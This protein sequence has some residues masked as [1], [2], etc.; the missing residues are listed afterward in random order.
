ME[1]LGAGVGLVLGVVRGP[2][3]SGVPPLW[4][5]RRRGLGWGGAWV[6]RAWCR[7]GGT[8]GGGGVCPAG[9]AWMNREDEHKE[10]RDM[11]LITDRDL[12]LMEPTLC[13]DAAGAA[14]VLASG[15]GTL[16]SGVLSIAGVN[17]A[18][19]GVLP[20]QLAVVGEQVVEIVSVS[21]AEMTV[22][23]MRSD[24]AGPLLTPPDAAAVPSR[25]LSFDHHTAMAHRLILS[26][27]GID[28]LTPAD[29][30]HESRITSGQNLRIVEVCTALEFIWCTVAGASGQGS[31]AAERSAFYSRRVERLAAVAVAEYVTPVST[32]RVRLSTGARQLVRG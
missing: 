26:Q 11:A 24:G 3:M 13:R 16:S 23:L 5:E 25:V 10:E 19:R 6:G 1:L 15:A 20:G 8:G 32:I 12:L 22:S 4:R 29:T 14:T 21:G 17:P 30:L 31:A 28:G 2:A 9:T 18:A 7:G 27:L